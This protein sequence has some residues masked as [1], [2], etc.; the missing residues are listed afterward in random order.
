MTA[1]YILHKLTDTECSEYVERTKGKD[2]SKSNTD[3]LNVSTH[4]YNESSDQNDKLSPTKGQFNNT[5]N[6]S[7]VTG[8]DAT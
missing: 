8:P 5:Q 3:S 6:K 2:T 4:A 7:A 1:Q